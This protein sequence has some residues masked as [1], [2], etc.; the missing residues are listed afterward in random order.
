M[1]PDWDYTASVGALPEILNP[2]YRDF[3]VAV[4]LPLRCLQKDEPAGPLFR[5]LEERP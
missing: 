1:Q 2:G 3:R 4:G 5:C